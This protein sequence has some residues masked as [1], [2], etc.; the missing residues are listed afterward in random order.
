MEIST[1]KGYK[2][3]K[4]T[5]DDQA[6]RMDDLTTHLLSQP[7]KRYLGILHHKSQNTHPGSSVPTILN[8]NKSVYSS[9]LAIL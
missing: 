5:E 4:I 8:T 6:A 7:I 2:A 3:A 9:H 1:I